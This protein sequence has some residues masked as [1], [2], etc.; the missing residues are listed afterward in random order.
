MSQ[1]DPR[2]RIPR[3]DALLALPPLAAAASRCGEAVVRAAIAGA[4]Q[5][6]RAGEIPPEQVATAAEAALPPRLT[7]LRPLLNATGVVVH[8]NLGR[9]PLS[10]AAVEALTAAA[11]LRRRGVRR[12]ERCPGQTRAGHAGRPA[13]GRAGRRGRARGQQRRRRARA[14]DDGAGRWSRG[15]RQPRRDGGDRRRVPPARP[16]RLDR[17]AA[18]RGRHDQ[19]D[20][21][22]ATTPTRSA[23]TR[24][25]SSR[26]TRATSGSR[27][28]RPRWACR[29]WPRWACR[30]SSTSAAAC[31]RRTRCFL[32]SPTPPPPWH[33]APRGHGQR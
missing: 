5:R 15:R 21:P 6:A 33:R 11:G 9:A 18:A 8:T 30:S 19:P 2:R 24:A 12:R 17:G 31:W 22:A 1:A 23:P 4:Q 3:T 10:Q 26:S 16:D 32:T 14:R 28:S 29:S 25:A 13:G 7:T 20:Q 27:A